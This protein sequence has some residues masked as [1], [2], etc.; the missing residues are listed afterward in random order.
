M[1]AGQLRER[2]HFQTRVEHDDGY[3][4]TVAEWATQFTVAARLKPEGRGEQVLAARL[5]GVQ[6]YRCTVRKSSETVQ[7]TEAWRAVD[8]RNAD[9]IFAVKSPPADF[10]EKGASLDM[11]VQSGV[12]A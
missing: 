1:T 2:L 9:R 5:S 8:A 12:A 10:S 7:I 3:G 11:L 6:T 4:N